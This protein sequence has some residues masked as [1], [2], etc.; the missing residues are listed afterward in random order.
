MKIR[1]IYSI[2]ISIVFLVSAFNTSVYGQVNLVKVIREGDIE[3]ANKIVD[4]CSVEELNQVVN[5]KMPSGTTDKTYSLCEAVRKKDSLLVKKILKK[6][7]NPNQVTFISPYYYTPLMKASENNDLAS[8]KLLVEYGANVNYQLDKQGKEY[9]LGFE[10]DKTALHFAAEKNSAEVAEFLIKSGANVNIQTKEGKTPL[11]KAVNYN[12]TD[13]QKESTLAN[14]AFYLSAEADKSISNYRESFLLKSR[15]FDVICVLLNNHADINKQDT[16]GN[17][18]L[19]YAI[20]KLD[21]YN[22]TRTAIHQILSYYPNVNIANN[23]GNTPLLLALREDLLF[24]SNL[25]LYL[26]ADV[27]AKSKAGES[28]FDAIIETDRRNN[29]D[30]DIETSTMFVANLKKLF[31]MGANDKGSGLLDWLSIAYYHSYLNNHIVDFVRLS[32]DSGSD[33][34]FSPCEKCSGTFDKF[35]KAY[36]EDSWNGMERFY[37]ILELFIEHGATNIKNKDAVMSKSINDGDERL[38]QLLIKNKKLF[39]QEQLQRALDEAKNR[40][41][42]LKTKNPDE[43]DIKIKIEKTNKIFEILEKAVAESNQGK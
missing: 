6:G 22:D 7:A 17:T 18:A 5:L 1:A 19:H 16:V 28:V 38:I 14:K 37:S 3:K 29:F 20:L 42:Y 24:E 41:S 25:L 36:Q 33:P 12:A 34:N 4:K 35:I 21:K 26:K 8:V 30:M 2:V 10:I 39:T 15:Y 11:M 40:I 32:L 13:A 9:L 31:E 27:T 43:K 23:A